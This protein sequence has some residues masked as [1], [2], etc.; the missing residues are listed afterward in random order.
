M[1]SRIRVLVGRSIPCPTILGA[2][3]AWLLL[4]PSPCLRAEDR[5][6]VA[7]LESPTG[8][9]L[10]RESAG[11][12]WKV[13]ANGGAVTD[14]VLLLALPGAHAELL[15]GTG[16]ARLVLIGN[17]PQLSPTPALESAVSLRKSSDLDFDIILDRGRILLANTKDKGQAKVQVRA[18]DEVWDLTLKEPGTQVTLELNGRWPPGI[19]FRPEYKRGEE[20]RVEM[21]LLVLKGSIELRV[22]AQRHTLNAPPGGALY[23][24]DSVAGPARSPARLPELPPWVRPEAGKSE[25]ALAVAASLKPL[26]ANLAKESAD[27]ALTELL[28][29]AG[30]E[31]DKKRA[32]RDREIAVTGFGAI[33]DLLRLVEAL[34]DSKHP[35]VRVIAVDTLRHWI[36]RA[37][38]QDSQLAKY[39]RSKD[40]SAAHTTIVLQ[41]LHSYGAD[42]IDDPL[43]Y[44]LLISYLR[45]EKLAIRELAAWHLYRLVPAGQNIS[46]DPAGSAEER[47]KAFKAW[48]ALIPNGKLPPE[49]KKK[50]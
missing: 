39:L 48:K 46:F 41:L 35:E 19:P 45:H 47:E 11:G 42:E 21:D 6:G 36:G 7:R 24:F 17:L 9:L 29:S 1:S 49:P 15:S 33:D 37:P 12:E 40:Y 34:S 30:Q 14:R 4:G 16:G 27:K 25:E 32:A 44:D 43:T 50:Q 26:F 8:T 18:R 28:A 13:I 31:S 2:C 20:P 23:H 22:D 38:G 5:D 3:L 10:R